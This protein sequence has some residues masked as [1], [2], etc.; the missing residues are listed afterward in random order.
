MFSTRKCP[1]VRWCKRRAAAG[2]AGGG[3]DP[4]STHVVRGGRGAGFALPVNLNLS[5]TGS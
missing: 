2:L 4:A 3:I 1:A 5:S